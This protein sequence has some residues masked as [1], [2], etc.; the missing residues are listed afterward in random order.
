LQQDVLERTAELEGLRKAGTALSA[1]QLREV[2][3]LADEQGRLADLARNLARQVLEAF[4]P[5]SEE[6]TPKNDK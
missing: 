6:E 3:S 4:R 1:E 5:E 2:D